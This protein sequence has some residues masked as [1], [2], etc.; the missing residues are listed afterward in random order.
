[1]QTDQNNPARN[2]STTYDLV[3]IG[4]G[5]AARAAA[6]EARRLG[7]T[8]AMIEHGAAGGTCLNVGCVPSKFLIAAAA[9]RFSAQ[10]SRFAGIETSASGA[11]L[12]LL[13]DDKDRMIGGFREAFHVKGPIEAGIDVL[14]GTASFA[15]SESADFVELTV[16]KPDEEAVRVRAGQVLIATGAAPFIPDIA[17]LGDV[18]V[19]TS[20]SAM[21]LDRV[22]AS[23]LVIGGNAIG[24]EQAQLFSRL[25]AKVTV[26]EVAPRIAPFEDPAISTALML[27]LSEEGIEFRTGANLTRVEAQDGG[28]RATIAIGDDTYQLSA[29]KLLMATGRRPVTGDL[30]LEMVG[31]Q[32]GPRGEVPVDEYLRTANPRIWAAGD[33]TGLAQLVYVASEQGTTA[34]HNAL[35]GDLRALDYTTLPRVTFTSPEVAAVGMTPAQAQAAK[36]PYEVR[37]FPVSFVLRAIVARHASGLIKLVSNRETD[38]ILGVHMVGE[39]A[40]EVIAAATYVLSAGFTVTQLATLWSPYFTMAESLKNVA[41]AAPV[42]QG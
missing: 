5:S 34:A 35:T 21:A 30:E 13:V 22:P 28:V 32:T 12:G 31:V 4:S 40:G 37:E 27:A 39:A 38:K 41:K 15:A 14:R 33:V 25:G 6:N 42:S 7:K 23:L 11:N 1:M 20:S 24:L 16:S 10:H 18:E 3:T 26:V 2:D 19:L 8:V 17:G 36:I 9:A 29:E